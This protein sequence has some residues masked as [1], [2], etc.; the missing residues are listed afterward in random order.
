MYVLTDSALILETSLNRLKMRSSRDSFIFGSS[1]KTC[2]TEVS[3]SDMQVPVNYHQYQHHHHQQ[4]EGGER[5]PT[6]SL[7]DPVYDEE[8]R[9]EDTFQREGDDDDDDADDVDDDGDVGMREGFSLPSTDRLHHEEAGEGVVGTEEPLSDDDIER[10]GHSHH[11]THHTGAPTQR[12]DLL[13]GHSS[14][15]PTG[16]SELHLNRGSFSDFGGGDDQND[17]GSAI[18][19]QQSQMSP[20]V[21][22][23]P[24]H[25]DS[26][27][28]S[29]GIAL[30]A[31]LQAA[32]PQ[33][34][35]HSHSLSPSQQTNTH[36]KLMG[37][38]PLLENSQSLVTSSENT[39]TARPAPFNRQA[40]DMTIGSSPFGEN[41][42]VDASAARVKEIKDRIL[43]QSS[44][45][46][47]EEFNVS[48][49][50]QRQ[51]T[52]S[53]NTIVCY[54]LL[55]FFYFFYFFL[56]HFLYFPYFP[57]FL[58]LFFLSFFSSAI[59]EQGQQPAY[60]LCGQKESQCQQ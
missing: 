56:L 36:E 60:L 15:G 55:D 32:L 51:T 42:R 34:P 59:Y 9:E 6:V 49:P 58:F 33:A 29:S 7:G 23:A 45:A 8:D 4:E 21:A 14:P 5:S 1:T 35:T 48:S 11:H 39:F 13:H 52:A 17:G 26:L 19:M 44:S 54:F 27:A 10:G 2:Q 50:A 25:L 24:S 30:E 46:A 18:V 22:P 47:L 43:S 20:L 38:L 31:R 16:R 37:G 41:G 12:P 40:S 57:Y 53:S 3:A 28:F